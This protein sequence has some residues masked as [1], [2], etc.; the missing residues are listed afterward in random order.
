MTDAASPATHSRQRKDEPRNLTDAQSKTLP[1]GEYQDSRQPAL[2]LYVS[3]QGVRTW[4]LYKWLKTAGKDGLG[5]PIRMKVGNVTSMNVRDARI[6]AGALAL[7]IEEGIDPR[8]NKRTGDGAEKTLRQILGMYSARLKDEGKKQWYWAERKIAGTEKFAGSYADWLNKPLSAI[9]RPMLED[10]QHEIAFGNSA[11]K[12]KK[13]GVQAATISLKALRA[14]FAYAEKKELYAGKNVAKMV[15][16]E[17]SP[18]R[19]RVM[20]EAEKARILNVLDNWQE[21]GFRPYVRPFFRLLM[22]TGVRWGNLVSAK[23]ED[24]NLK[25][26]VWTIPAA[27]SKGS[28]EMRI[29]LRDEAIELLEGQKGQHK[30][31]VFPSPNKASSGHLMDPMLSWKRVLEIAEVKD[32][33]TPHDLRRSFGSLLLNREV[34]MEVVSKLMGHRN[35]ATTAKHYAFVTDEEAARHL[36][37][38]PG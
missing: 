26:K 29:Q 10:R 1:P 2:R 13:R 34:P 32:R 31:W 25:A 9:T 19:E 6:K 30:V 16:M 35:V 36:N 11:L 20:S 33:L 3:D 28:H 7:K 17:D 14:V 23:W 8:P 24:I 4:G 18:R 21:N 5:A 12:I 38:V 22:L 15:D 27:K 37:R